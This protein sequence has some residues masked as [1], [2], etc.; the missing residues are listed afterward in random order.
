MT[1]R[2]LI[3]DDS[4]AWTERAVS[5]TAALGFRAQIEQASTPSLFAHR[6]WSAILCAFSQ[7]RAD[8]FPQSL[9]TPVILLCAPDE[10]ER[11]LTVADVRVRDVISTADADRL[12][13]ILRR[14]L[15][16]LERE[17][18]VE[19]WERIEQVLNASDARF[20]TV[21]DGFNDPLLLLDPERV[22]RHANG[23][24]LLKFNYEAADVLGVALDTL[25]PAVNIPTGVHHW[26]GEL[27]IKCRDGRL[28]DIDQTVFTLE[29]DGALKNYAVVL[30][31]ITARK[32]AELMQAR[33]TRDL[34]TLLYI[35]SH[36]LREP[37]RAIRS[38]AQMVVDRYDAQLDDKGRDFLRRIV[39]GGERMDRLIDDILQ[40]S[41]AQR[42]IT[43]NQHVGGADLIGA[44]L[45]MLEPQIESL[46]AVITIEPD[47]PTVY[48]DRMWAVQALYN[49]LQNALKFTRAG[50]AP[51]IEVGRWVDPARGEVGFV[52][53]DRG[54]GVAP[55]HADRIFGLFQRAVG[56]EIEGTG[57]GLA[58]VREIAERHGGRAWVQ[59]R[60]NGGSQFL[61]TFAEN[62][63]KLSI[64]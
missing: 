53:R 25:L 4:A 39:R 44:A 62:G 14:E 19:D 15:R 50:V 46:H 38:F 21:I 52:I 5:A 30:S 26:R 36:D 63:G 1:K 41:R 2:I 34:E 22:I 3:I 32:Q 18:A 42:L 17:Q 45:T 24:F 61:I 60:S 28:L 37:L 29:E 48:V 33:K 40:L 20:W 64:D 43:P 6:I 54:I 23:A 57:A 12:P 35:T 59:P 7:W 55:E 16:T 10:V 49:L 13:F 56:R 47:L 31:D 51:E 8:V 11:A 27:R 58:I 9:R